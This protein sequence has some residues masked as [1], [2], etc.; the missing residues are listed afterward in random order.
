MENYKLD[1]YFVTGLTDAEGCFLIVIKY[2]KLKT[3]K[4]FGLRFTI[5]MLNNET[6]LLNM[7]KNFFDCGTLYY[8]KK[9][10]IVFTVQDFY[11][12]KNKII[13][14]FAKYPLRGTKYLDFLSFKEAFH[15][16]ESKEH[17]IQEGVNKVDALRKS[18]NT[19]RVFSTDV[20]YSPDHT[21]E[22]NINYTSLDGHYVNGFITGDGSFILSMGKYFGYMR[23]SISQHK[24]NRLLMESIAKFF[25]S[26]SKVYSGRLNDIQINLAGAKL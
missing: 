19:G 3:K 5:E 6:E 17:L 13:P 8:T 11:S 9:G 26:P 24:N 23:L 4:Y 7:V 10:S 22:N 21:K 16:I 25:K 2:N 15:M 12:I 14:H 18:M 20:S 1:P